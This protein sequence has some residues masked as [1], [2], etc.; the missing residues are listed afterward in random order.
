M[1]TCKKHHQSYILSGLSGCLR[2][3]SRRGNVS[4]HCSSVAFNKP[5]FVFHTFFCRVTALEVADADRPTDALPGYH[6]AYASCNI[7]NVSTSYRNSPPVHSLVYYLLAFWL[8]SLTEV[9][10]MATHS[11]R[12]CRGWKDVESDSVHPLSKGL[13]VS[14][15]VWGHATKGRGLT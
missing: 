15:R 3:Y 9:V 11:D 14:E 13:I 1:S 8:Q 10:N 5:K 4:K 6:E 2:G 7:S 12:G